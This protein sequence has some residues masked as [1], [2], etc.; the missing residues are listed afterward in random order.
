MNPGC[1][2][3]HGSIWDQLD[4]RKVMSSFQGQAFP[5]RILCYLPAGLSQITPSLRPLNGLLN[6][7]RFLTSRDPPGAAMKVLKIE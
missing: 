3:L 6:I 7:K 5:A 2:G 1:L 4:L